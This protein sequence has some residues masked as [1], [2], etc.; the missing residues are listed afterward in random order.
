MRTAGTVYG[1]AARLQTNS[2]NNNTVFMLRKNGAD[3][4]LTFTVATTATGLFE[5]TTHT[6]TIAAGDL[7]VLRSVPASGSTGTFSLLYTKTEFDT[8][9]STTNTTTRIGTTVGS[10]NTGHTTAST[11]WYYQPQSAIPTGSTVNTTE[12]TSQIKQQYSATF[13]NFGVK[14]TT[15]SRTTTTTARLRKNTANGNMSV[16]VTAGTT[17]WVED[18]VNTDSV[19][20][21]DLVNYS[22]TTGTGTQALS[23]LGFVCDYVTTTNPGTGHATLGYTS[24]QSISKATTNYLALLG[25]YNTALTTEALAQFKLND[26]YTFKGLT[27]TATQ[28]NVNAASTILLRVNG[29]DTSLSVSIASNTIGVFSDLVH[30]VTIA[31]GDLVNFKIVVATGGSGD[32]LTLTSIGIWTEIAGAST[33]ITATPTSKTVT[34]KFITHYP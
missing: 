28:N 13:K 5:D 25:K 26:T 33:F 27:V 29:A 20:A 16:A 34:N 19:V 10:L 21:G 31:A 15:N 3:T 11:T 12:S 30:T 1:L 4:T 8:T 24:A 7:L 2:V 22:L 32:T 9:A 23:I 18:T 14:F 17:G 6:E